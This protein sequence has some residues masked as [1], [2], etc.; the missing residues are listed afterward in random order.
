MKL[1]YKPTEEYLQIYD[2]SYDKCGYPLF[3]VYLNGAWV[4]KSA[5]NFMEYSPW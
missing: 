1:F 2:V 4:R 5:K 3:L